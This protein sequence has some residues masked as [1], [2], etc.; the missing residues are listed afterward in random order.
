[1]AFWESFISAAESLITS[2]T[3]GGIFLVGFLGTSTIFLP[4]PIYLIIFFARNL[5]L[6]PF[7]VGVVAGIGSA[8]GE[9]TG[10]A[11]GYGSRK[12]L[13]K[14]YEKWFERSEKWFEKNGFL[15]ILIFALT[16]LPDDIV[17]ILGGA[18]KYDLK[19]FFLA[20]ALGKTI[21]CLA[22][23]YSGYLILPYFQEIYEMLQW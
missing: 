4:F 15:T 1:M 5:G 9:I 8:L 22:I 6:N 11:V 20:S 16:P 3:Y 13:K 7:I 2:F 18:S 12:F 21:L 14:K 23:A 10:Y 19:K 17:G